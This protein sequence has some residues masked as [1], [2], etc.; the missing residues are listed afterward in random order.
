VR[1]QITQGKSTTFRNYVYGTEDR[2][3]AKL[4]DAIMVCSACGNVTA[5]DGHIIDYLTVWREI[6]WEGL[7]SFPNELAEHGM[8]DLMSESWDLVSR[9]AELRAMVSS[10]VAAG[11]YSGGQS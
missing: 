11:R 3:K 10:Y 4:L 2:L 5:D 7:G 1:A 6:A 9:V 8:L